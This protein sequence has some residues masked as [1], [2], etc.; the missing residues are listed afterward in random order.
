MK[1]KID[2]SAASPEIIEAIQV[3]AEAVSSSEMGK[4]G[5]DKGEVSFE[6]L[7]TRLIELARDGKREYLE[8]LKTDPSHKKRAE[9]PGASI[10][11]E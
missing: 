5:Q 6:M 3:L 1:K 2:L 9:D 8:C 4:Q 10:K 11:L 7:R